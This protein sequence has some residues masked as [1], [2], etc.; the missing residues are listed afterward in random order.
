MDPQ[1]HTLTGGADHRDHEQQLAAALRDLIRQVDM[2]DYRDRDGRPVRGSQAFRQAQFLV[3]SF[4]LTHEQL[5]NTL[6][7]C[8]LF[9]DLTDAARNLIEMG[10]ADPSSTP[11]EYRTWTTGP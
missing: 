10:K 2:S 3:D 9:G 5:C 8:N 7:D 6:D 11:S 1:P 4:G